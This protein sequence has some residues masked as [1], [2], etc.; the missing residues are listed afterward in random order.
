M[1]KAKT[2]KAPWRK[3]NPRKRAGTSTKRS[4]TQKATV[5]RAAAKAG[6]PYPNL[7]HNRRGTLLGDSTGNRLTG[8]RGLAGNHARG[9]ITAFLAWNANLDILAGKVRLVIHHHRQDDGCRQG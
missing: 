4:S 9:E 6:R 2:R 5:R 3:S 7:V 8:G 1:Q